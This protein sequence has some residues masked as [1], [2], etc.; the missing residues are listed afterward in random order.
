[1]ITTQQTPLRVD[2]I[3]VNVRYR[4][5]EDDHLGGYAEV[6][7]EAPRGFAPVPGRTDTYRGRLKPGTAVEFVYLSGGLRPILDRQ[8]PG[9]RRAVH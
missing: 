6:D 8:T 2:E 7:I 3:E 5:M 1:M 9:E 4:F